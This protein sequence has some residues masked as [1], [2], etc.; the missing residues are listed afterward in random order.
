MCFFKR[1]KCSVPISNSAV[2][3]LPGDI[4]AWRLENGLPHIGIVSHYFSE[5]TGRLKIVHNIGAGVQIEDELFSWKH[6][7][8]YRWKWESIP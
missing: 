6:L 4:V 2:D 1:K 5:A 8:H 7:G 3:Y